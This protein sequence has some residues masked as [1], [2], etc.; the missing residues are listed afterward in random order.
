MNRFFQRLRPFIRIVVRRAGFV[1]ALA[2][3]LS[4]LGLFFARN[5]SIDTD[6]ANLVPED[7]PSVQALER[8]KETV[9]AE[10]EAAVAIESPS[11]EANRAF[12]EAFIPRALALKGEAYPEPYFSRVDYRNDV[13]FLENN[14]LY[15]ATPEELDRL[16]TYLREKVEEAKLEANPFYFDL[17][18]EDEAEPDTVAAELRAVY[19]EIVAK[20]YPISDDSTTMVLRF[21]PTG[22]QTDIGFLEDMYR[23]LERLVREMDPASYHPEMKVTLAGRL[24]RQLT[25]V[26]TLERD[27]TR[28]FGAGVSAVL[29]LVVL[30]FFYKGYRAR[31]GKTFSG[32]ILLAELA[33]T[34]VMALVIGVPLLMSL[35]WTF[36]VAYLAFG[37]LNLMTSTL[38]LVLFGLGIDFGIHFYARY[39]EERAHGHGV[40]EAAEITFTSTGQAI[41]V[42]ALTTALGLYVLVVADF[43]GFS[44]F[45]FISGTGIVLALV[46]M[47]VVMPA[48]IAV[49]ERRR[50]LNLETTVD[51]AG[52]PAG[53]TRRFPAA[54]GIVLAS[55]A[56]V[57]AAL[58]FLPR[59]GF[60]Y[61][62]G[63]LEPE[64]TEYNA[65]RDVV[66]RV[67]E[68]SPYRNPA[69]IVADAPEEVPAVV[70]ALREKMAQDTLSPTIGRVESLQDRFPMTPAAQQA[71]LDR[72]AE[73]RAL[74]E[75]PF[76]QAEDDP[77]L[78]RLRR[79]AQT[80]TPIG[81]D[82]VPDFLKRRFSSKTGEIGNFVIIYPSVGLADGRNS[83]AFSDDVGTV[84]TEDG[85]VYHAGSTSLVAAD[86]LRLMQAE[87]PYMV[88]ATFVIVA[89][90]MWLNFGTL[91]WA[92]LALLPLI[93]GV[94]WMLLLVEIFG[95]KL[96]FY[97]II[98]LP[99]IL[100][101]G[102]DAGVHLVHRYREEGPGS[103]W[104]VL[105]SSGEHVAMAS[106]TTMMGFAGPLLSFHPGLRSIGELAV[107]GIGATLAAA[108]L[109]LPALL[110][111]LEDRAEEP[112]TG[113]RVGR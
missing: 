40:S 73:I 78:A 59:V 107:L 84:R 11:F 26:R 105:R 71:R 23:D 37:K 20:E 85:R 60:E 103:I 4:A 49:F 2:V 109:F 15:F 110:Q 5:L 53:G 24:Y 97:N 89:L 91:R 21:Y 17:E 74:L 30:Y 80:R 75:D 39:T 58:V 9:G 42:G 104:R 10:S 7:Y 13:T 77:D 83:I 31:A 22:A 33:R 43:K 96:N 48:L 3:G 12:A 14:A 46:A 51:G 16:E 1:L 98:V 65:R 41:T 86:M 99:A 113:A 112:A 36:G 54:R 52:A 106:I 68:P 19:N 61:D 72:I 90:L 44:E 27:V 38:G 92:A 8:L 50:L 47:L 28:S 67:Y 108:L 95:F 88:A 82:Q 63:K 64:Y 70:A 76:L 57:V 66:R 55:L 6:L 56:A 34:P 81:L 45:G 79:A 100:G 69:Y 111:W 62:F 93:V 18:E 35:S 32:R 101:I 94:L 29:L 87:A 25:E 102:N